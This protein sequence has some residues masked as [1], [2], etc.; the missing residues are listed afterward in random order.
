MFKDCFGYFFGAEESGDAG[1]KGGFAGL[2]GGA[3]FSDIPFQIGNAIV[4]EH[5]EPSLFNQR[6]AAPPITPAN[7][8]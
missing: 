7:K 5:H 2:E 1:E 4:R 8:K 3:F 6:N